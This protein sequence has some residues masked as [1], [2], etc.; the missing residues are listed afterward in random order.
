MPR[1]LRNFFLFVYQVGKIGVNGLL[2]LTTDIKQLTHALKGI[3]ANCNRVIQALRNNDLD[4]KLYPNW[5]DLTQPSLFPVLYHSTESRGDLSAATPVL[6]FLMS[7]CSHD[8]D[9]LQSRAH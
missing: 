1:S 3:V 9:W 8:D 6:H 2:Q 7:H 5:P 4:L